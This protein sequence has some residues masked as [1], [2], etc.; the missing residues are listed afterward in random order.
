M[1]RCVKKTRRMYLIWQ[2]CRV[3]VRV[4]AARP[5]EKSREEESVE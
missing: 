5:S 4:L 1:S 3:T 2:R